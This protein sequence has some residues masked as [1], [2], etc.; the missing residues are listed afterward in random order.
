MRANILTIVQSAAGA[1]LIAALGLAIAYFIVARYRVETGVA[2]TS[3]APVAPVI[4]V[5]GGAR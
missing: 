1:A 2:A 5:A 3:A 4:Y